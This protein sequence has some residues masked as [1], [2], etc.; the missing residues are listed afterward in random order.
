MRRRYTKPMKDVLHESRLF[1]ARTIVGF[2]AIAACTL[3]LVGRF[4]YLQIVHHDE[5][6]TQS[7]NNRVKLRALAPN[8]GLIFDRNGTLLADNRPAYRLELVP[9]QV[10]DLDE[11]LNRLSDLLGLTAE[12]LKRFDELRKARRHFQGVAIKFR[13]TESEVA[14]FAVNRHQ[15]PGVDVVPYLTRSY[16]FG[17]DL[18]HVLG[19]VGRIDARDL[20]RLDATRYSAT[21]H[22]GK[23]GIERFYEDLLHGEVGYERIE[24]NAEG[25]ILGVLERTPPQPGR[26]LYLTL[27]IRLQQ[28]ATKALGN[29]AGAIVA[30]H[31]KSG[32]VLAM[33]SLPD[34]DPNPFVNG[35]TQKHYQALLDSKRR[36]LFNRALQGGYVPGSTLKPYI[37]LAGLELDV[38]SR[39]YEMNS[40][41]FYKLPGQSREYRDW[42][43][44]G[45][46][47]VDMEQA[48]AQSVNSYFYELAVELGIQRIHDYLQQFGFGDPTGLDL[49]GEARGVLPSPAWK[50]GTHGQPWYPGETVIS[51]IGQGF[52]VTTPLQLTQASAILAM[53]GQRVTPHLRLKQTLQDQPGYQWYE[54]TDEPPVPQRELANWETIVDGMVGVLHGEHGTARAIVTEP[55]PYE[56]ASKTGT[57]QVFGRGDSDEEY[58]PEELEED[59]RHHAVFIAFAPAIDPELVVTVIVEHGGGGA[60]VAAPIGM[61]V[62]QT[63]LGDIAPH[64]VNRPTIAAR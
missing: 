41:G 19:Y 32:E 16:P 47:L 39:D 56:I 10:S 17:A 27:D 20:E 51:G 57:A 42:K 44:G 18:G 9:E 49:Y 30:M 46:G 4:A 1:R 52:F 21:S 7:E 14:R 45:H 48:I 34:Y 13:M 37:G 29:Y 28:A 3:V 50:S 60:G 22:V 26:D 55:L 15:F 54:H 38:V 59:L 53:R 23:T 43:R 35:V 12:E 40:I 36:P 24:T 33:V 58:D 61:E 31:P 64:V 11:T 5:F 6:I 2:L 25:R 8:R 63:Y 62:I